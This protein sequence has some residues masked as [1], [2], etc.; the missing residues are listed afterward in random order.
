MKIITLE[1][2][3]NDL[4]QEFSGIGAE[5]GVEQ[6][7]FSEI[8]CLNNNV[9]K[10][11]SIDA[12]KSYRGYRD[13]VR[14]QK[15]DSFYELSKMRLAKYNCEIVRKF[16]KEA[17]SDFIDGALDFVYIDANHEY[18]H[19]QDDIM[20]WVK[21]VRVGGIVS[22]HDYVRRK[23][24]DSFYGVVRA[25][26]EYVIENKIEELVIYRGDTSPSWKFIK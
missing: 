13:H 9:K 12:W 16:S 11:Y 23:G 25:V 1:K 8:I 22:G 15:L 6:G 19:V 3:R 26:N 14:Q 10:L 18:A 7:V 24:Q 20:L 4:A 2:T 17:A 21:K 5:I